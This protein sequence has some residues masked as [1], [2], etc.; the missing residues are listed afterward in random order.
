MGKKMKKIITTIFSLKSIYSVNALII[1]AIFLVGTV[2]S[3]Q[4][5]EISESQLIEE[6]RVLAEREAMFVNARLKNDWEKIYD[7]Q[8][9]GFRKKISIDEIRYLEGWA[10]YDYREQSKINAHI[11]GFF[12]PTLAFMKKN[13]NKKDP[14]GFPVPRKYSWSKNPFIEIKRHTLKNISISKDGKYAKVKVTL[15][16]R[17]R[18]NPILARGLYE[19]DSEYSL[20]DYW[21]KVDGS[22]FITLLS[23]PVVISGV[24]IL[25]YFVPNDKSGWEKTKF[26]EID[27]KNLIGS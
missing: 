3:A 5:A 23:K 24:S 21:E 8:H 6:A 12:T 22:W 9:P 2:T 27:P 17:E 19:F 14:L 26:V 11:S 10:A 25:N 1:C 13:P 7:F 15:E 4:A 20:T 16:G 18:I